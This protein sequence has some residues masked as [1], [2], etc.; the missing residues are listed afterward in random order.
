MYRDSENRVYRV[1]GINLATPR[2]FLGFF[3]RREIA[4][5]VVVN[6]HGISYG[7]TIFYSEHKQ[8]RPFLLD[9]HFRNNPGSTRPTL[10]EEVNHL[11]DTVLI[12]ID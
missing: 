7:E 10:S 11:G 8:D 1:S 6:P 5:D 2:T 12:R 4:L 3:S 9:A